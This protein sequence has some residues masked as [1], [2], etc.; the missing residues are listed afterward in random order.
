MK[1]LKIENGKLKKC[2]APL[3]GSHP[4]FQFSIFNF[5]FPEAEAEG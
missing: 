2:G 5:Q 1:K 4:L 3:H